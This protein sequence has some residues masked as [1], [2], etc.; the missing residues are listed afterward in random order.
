LGLCGEKKKVSKE[1]YER[2]LKNAK[3]ENGREKNYH[4]FESNC[5]GYADKYGV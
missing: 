3:S 5:Q 2:L 1:K 4:L